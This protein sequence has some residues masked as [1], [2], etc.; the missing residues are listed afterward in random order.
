VWTECFTIE[1]RLERGYPEEALYAIQYKAWTDHKR[2]LD[3]NTRVWTPFTQCPRASV[4]GSY[5]IMN[6]FKVHLVVS[7]LSVIQYTGTEVECVVDGYTGCIQIIDKGIHL[8]FKSFAPEEFE[9][10]MLTNISSHH[11]TQVEV[12]YWVN[13]IWNKITEDT[14]KNT[15]KHV[16]H[17]FRGEFGDPSL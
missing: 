6:E 16:G 5:M 4:H 11:P 8:P 7:C 13:I 14:I 12:A 1:K 17:F 9:N 2:F 10:W 15:W 3:W